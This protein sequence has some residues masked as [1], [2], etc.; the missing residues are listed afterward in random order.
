MKKPTL[1]YIPFLILLIFSL[2]ALTAHYS[3]IFLRYAYMA[4]DSQ[5]PF[6]SSDNFILAVEFQRR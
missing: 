4:S 5:L 2:S 6:T 3:Y 1:L